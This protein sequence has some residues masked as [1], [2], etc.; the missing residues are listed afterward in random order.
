MN[1]GASTLTMQNDGNLVLYRPDGSSAWA[2]NTNHSVGSSVNASY[3]LYS[4]WRLKSADSRMEAVMQQDGNFVVYWDSSPL[5]STGTWGSGSN[6]VVMQSDGNL[7]V[8]DANNV[9]HWA[10]GTNGS[11]GSVLSMQNDGNLVIKTSGGA[12]VWASNT[13]GH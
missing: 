6:R 4:N 5:W 7:V 2:S 12:V 3:T 13:G 9:A 11:G 10:S 8:Y 1:S